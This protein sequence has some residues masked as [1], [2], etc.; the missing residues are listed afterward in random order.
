V[1]EGGMDSTLYFPVLSM[2]RLN[3]TEP[4]TFF[5]ILPFWTFLKGF[6]FIKD[7]ET[8]NKTVDV[9]ETYVLSV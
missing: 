6:Y 1:L 2:N 5:S 9:D 4:T 3:Q 7:Q 8:K